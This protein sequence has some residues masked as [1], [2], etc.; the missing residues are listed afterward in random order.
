MWFGS[1]HLG[2]EIRD[3]TKFEFEFNDVQILATS[4]VFEAFLSNANSEK[5]PIYHSERQLVR[6]CAAGSRPL[7]SNAVQCNMFSALFVYCLLY[8]S[9]SPRD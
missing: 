4:G 3:V 2:H 6:M 8:T 1:R 9:P 5:F 7:I